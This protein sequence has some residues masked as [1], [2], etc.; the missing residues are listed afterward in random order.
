MSLIQE[1][2]E[3][4][5]Y[6]VAV[7]TCASYGG[8]HAAP[9]NPT[10]CI[11]MQFDKRNPGGLLSA[12]WRSRKGLPVINMSGCP[13]HPNAITKLFGGQWPHSS[14]YMVFGGVTTPANNRHLIDSLSLLNKLIRGLMES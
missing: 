14:Y 10:D 1:L 11:G 5:E 9:P 3:K 8:I 2:T 12:E 6:V 7:G 4:A 13:A